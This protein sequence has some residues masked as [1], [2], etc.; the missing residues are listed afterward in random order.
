[1]W[2]EDAELWQQVFAPVFREFAEEVV[3]RAAPKGS[4]RVLDIGTGP[5][6]ALFAAAPLLGPEGRATGVDRSGAMIARARAALAGGGVRAHVIQMD[7][8][9][10]EFPDHW[11][12]VAISN[13][14]IPF[15]GFDAVLAEVRRVLKPGGRLV[16]SDWATDKVAAI[17][18]FRDVLAA[19]RTANP[20]ARLRRMRDA[21]EVWMR[22]AERFEERQGLEQAIRAA[23][24]A[25]VKGETVSHTIRRFTL[26]EF[27]AAQ[28]SRHLAKMEVSEMTDA[29]RSA[30]LAAVR[31]ALG[32][33][34]REGQVEILWPMF[35]LFAVK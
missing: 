35:Y 16:F 5:G 15:L 26:D 10:L 4:D 17:R 23:G 11:F 12:D 1:M 34:V 14:G 32:H 22:D 7:A 3:R 13:C 8:A 27:V 6:T 29:A 20:S 33:L 28:T 31:E 24:F 9:S 18:I 19:H 30:F 21:G 25:Q 2:E